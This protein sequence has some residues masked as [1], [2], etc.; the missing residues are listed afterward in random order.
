MGCF[1]QQKQSKV[2]AQH[3]VSEHNGSGYARASVMV[4]VGINPHSQRLLET[5]ARLAAGLHADLIAVHIHVPGAQASLYRSNLQWQFEQAQALGA[6][7]EELEG[8]DVAATLVAHARR[9][10]TTLVV[11]GQSDVSRWYE[12]RHGTLATR[13]LHEIA[14]HHAAIDV[15]V[16][17]STSHA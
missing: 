8:R 17:T 2:G 11:I 14:Q 10:G 16:V 6:V 13:V 3:V 5:A 15:Y 12:M 4:A 7:T 9:R 1:V